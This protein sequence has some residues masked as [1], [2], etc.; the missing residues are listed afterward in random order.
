MNSRWADA[1]FTRLPAVG[2][3]EIVHGLIFVV[4]LSNSHPA[5]SLDLPVAT[6]S[7]FEI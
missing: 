6:C 2:C 7:R 3:N 5:F 1:G 4:L